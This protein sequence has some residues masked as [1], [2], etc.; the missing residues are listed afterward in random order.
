M[1]T[2]KDVARESGLAVGTI[3]RYLNGA[4]VKKQNRETIEQAIERL[5]YQRNTLARSMKTGKSMTIA[6]VVPQLANMFCMRVIESVERVLENY[7]YSV[8]VTDCNGMENRQTEKITMLKNRMVD[9]FVLMPTGSDA[10]KV[11]D[12]AGD[13]PVVLID[14][15][16]DLPIF[17]S[18]VVNNCEATYDM[19]GRAVAQGI[20]KIGMIEGPQDIYSARERLRGF[21]MALGDY[22]LENT[23]H[24]RGAY[25]AQSGYDA[26][27]QLLGYD[28][29]AVFVSNYEQTLG[30]IDAVSDSQADVTILG[31]DSIEL[32]NTVKQPYLFISQPVE[33]IGK[34]AAEL[35]LA[36]IRDPDKEFVNLVLKI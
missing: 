8:I 36:R 3:S 17:D 5:G 1:V 33:A 30:A 24:V 23:Y 13:V 11:R 20:R 4:S 6:V 29:D 34:R 28:L 25:S 18:V 19:V 35:L 26:M 16:M 32:V 10:Q 22:Q 9:G 27:K 31:F 7:D 2:I 14:R 15:L 21:N 12:A